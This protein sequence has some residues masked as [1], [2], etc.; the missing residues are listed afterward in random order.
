MSREELKCYIIFIF[1]IFYLNFFSKSNICQ[2]S[3]LYFLSNKIF[4]AGKGFDCLRD[5]GN[6]VTTDMIPAFMFGC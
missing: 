6:G 3:F 5:L 4:V 1:T 2:M